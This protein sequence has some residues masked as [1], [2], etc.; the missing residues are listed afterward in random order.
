MAE[1]WIFLCGVPAAL[2]V[3]VFLK[4]VAD[5]L[6]YIAWMLDARAAELAAA[7]AKAEDA[8]EGKAADGGTR[9]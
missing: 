1:W 5:R 6:R 2:G 3:L 9:R 4:V 8:A 7:T